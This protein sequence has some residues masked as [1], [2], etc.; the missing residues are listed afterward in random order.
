MN[1]FGSV[2]G[3]STAALIDSA[4]GSAIAAGCAPD[5]DRIMGTIDMQVHF[6]ARAKGSELTAEG[7]MVRAGRAVAV[8][9]VEVRDDQGELVA[10]GTA[11]FRLGA[12][13]SRRNED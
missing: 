6:L 12:P 9:Q 11:T 4:A 2:H 5:S 8:A 3:G 7:R 13:G 1:P 10:L